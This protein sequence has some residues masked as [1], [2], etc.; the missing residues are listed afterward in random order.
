M[1]P[2]RLPQ[3]YQTAATSKAGS[4]V[5]HAVGAA[6]LALTMGCGGAAGVSGG[7]SEAAIQTVLRLDA[8]PRSAPVHLSIQRND[9]TL[10]AAESAN[11]IAKAVDVPWSGLIQ[12]DGA[13][14]DVNGEL[15]FLKVPQGWLAGVGGAQGAEHHFRGET[16][17]VDDTG[18]LVGAGDYAGLLHAES[19]NA[20]W[21]DRLTCTLTLAKQRGGA[22]RGTYSCTSVTSSRTKTYDGEVVDFVRLPVRAPALHDLRLTGVPEIEDSAADGFLVARDATG[23]IVRRGVAFG[24]N[25]DAVIQWDLGGP[26][27]RLRFAARNVP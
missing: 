3:F 16:F 23:R 7:P 12:S 2:S 19:A 20:S 11:G 26:T 13:T 21:G 4:T 15:L 8:V 17:L 9:L 18:S 6:I 22:Y 25:G 5:R 27:E 1:R 14:R 24:S 10:S